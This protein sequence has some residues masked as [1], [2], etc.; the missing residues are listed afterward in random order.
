MPFGTIRM[1]EFLVH[2][3]TFNA[4][5]FAVFSPLF[6]PCNYILYIFVRAQHCQKQSGI[7]L[8]RELVLSLYLL[9]AN[10]IRIPRQKCMCSIL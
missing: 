5:T 10:V 1:L 7:A 8:N 3:T 9:I 4:I 6:Q 2:F